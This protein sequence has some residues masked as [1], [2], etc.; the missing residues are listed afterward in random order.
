[1][2]NE[3]YPPFLKWGDCKSKDKSKP[4]VLDLEIVDPEPFPLQYDWY[5]LARIDGVDKNIPLRAKTANK[6]LYREYMKL[7]KDGKIKTGTKVIIKT[8]LGKSSRNPERDLRDFE[9]S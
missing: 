9:V 7:L 6:K 3:N 4:D 2:S 5:V 1:M 8:W